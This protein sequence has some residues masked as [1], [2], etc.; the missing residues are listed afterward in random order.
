MFNYFASNKLTTYFEPI[1][2]EVS[3]HHSF[4]A[5]VHVCHCFPEAMSD[6]IVITN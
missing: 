3:V 4:E 1:Q 2:L 6:Y 5:V